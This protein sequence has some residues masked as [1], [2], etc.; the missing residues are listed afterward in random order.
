MKKFMSTITLFALA[1]HA[2]LA[3]LGVFVLAAAEPAH[4]F[5]TYTCATIKNAPITIGIAGSVPNEN[6]EAAGISAVL[7]APGDH[8]TVTLGVMGKADFLAMIQ[9]DGNAA[10][11]IFAGSYEGSYRTGKERTAEYVFDKGNAGTYLLASWAL[12]KPDPNM[13][14]IV[15]FRCKNTKG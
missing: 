15:A 7:F 2:M 8:M 6:Y 1:R 11:P 3:A 4:A 14:A 5:D 9:A 12:S 13:S 10:T